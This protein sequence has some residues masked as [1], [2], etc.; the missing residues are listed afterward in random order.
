MML[1]RKDAGGIALL[2]L[3]T[4]FGALMLLGFFAGHNSIAGVFVSVAFIT[5]F[6][7]VGILWL[8]DSR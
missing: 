4:L 6:A 3:V 2:A 8:L 1:G 7:G 5:L